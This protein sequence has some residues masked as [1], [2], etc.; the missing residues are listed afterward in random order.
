MA[1]LSNSAAAVESQAARRPAVLTG[2]QLVWGLLLVVGISGQFGR[3]GLVSVTGRIGS[4]AVLVIAGWTWYAL[5]SRNQRVQPYP[6]L[7]ALGMTLGFLGDL[8]MAGLVPIPLKEP[9]LA[10]TLGGIGSFALGHIAYMT[11]IVRF[12]RKEQLATRHHWLKGILPWQ[13][14]G[15][16]GWTMVALPAMS[17]T[18]LVWPALPYSLLLAG[19]AGCATALYLGEAK[20]LGLAVGGGLF[21]L[22]DLILATRMFGNGF[23][24]AGELVWATYGPGQM[25]IV[26]SIGSALWVAGQ[27]PR[28]ALSG[29]HA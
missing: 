19:T 12:G 7:I 9:E 26:Y 18:V 13:L 28:R 6:L 17:K 27:S 24:L 14:V 2:M 22:S 16:V 1:T 15:L 23:P 20:F 8:F 11:G 4:S 3:H 10:S 25:L 5:S 21:L 29:S